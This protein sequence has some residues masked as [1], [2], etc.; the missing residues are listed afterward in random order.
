MFMYLILYIFLEKST[1]C[2][3]D[4]SVQI[5][6]FILH[7]KQKAIIKMSKYLKSTVPHS[8]LVELDYEK[9]QHILFEC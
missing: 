3:A 5:K 8:T 4:H 9:I 1:I 7:I 2:N 6:I